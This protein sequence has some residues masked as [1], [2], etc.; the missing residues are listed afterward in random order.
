MAEMKE[1]E[2][3]LADDAD[4]KLVRRYGALED[5]FAGL[6]GY[7]A[8]AEAA[9]ICANLGLPDR[10]LGADDGHPVGRP[11]PPHRA[12]PHPVPRRRRERRRH[13]AARRAHQPP[14]R[15]LDHLAARLP[16]QPQGRPH[17][18]LPRRRAAG[19]GGQQGLVPRRQPLGGRR[20]QPGLEGVPGAA[21]DR[22]APPQPG[23]GQRGEEGRRAD[24]A[25]RQD[26]GQGHQDGRGAEHGPPRREAA[27]RA[28]RRCAS[29]TRWPRCASRPRRRAARPRSPRQASPSRTGRWR[30]SATSTWRST[31]APGWPSWASTAPAR[32][33]CCGCSPGCW[34]RTPA[35]SSRATACA[36]ATTPRSTRRST[37][38]GRSWSTCARRAADQ[39]DTDLRKI[40]GAFLFSGD[41]VRQARRRALRRREDPAGAGH[42]GLLRRERAAARRADQQPRPGQPRA[43]ARRDRPLPRAIVLVTHDPGAVTALKPDRA[44]LLPDGDEDA[45]SDDLLE[46]VELA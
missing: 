16:R 40:L 36:W 2:E 3:K 4:E 44:I 22:R 45:W 15:R 31:G 24:G 27:R 6:G 30:S 17:R 39:T 29:P 23:A 33:P 5:Q 11:A 28:W 10:V 37:S 20:V 32:P 41:D 18:D 26:A 25:G 35:R 13:P 12:G 21:R 7:A 8:E 14:R 9:R 34:S 38:T 43:G 46:L 42:P 19:V 1:L